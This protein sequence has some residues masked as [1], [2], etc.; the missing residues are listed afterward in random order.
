[1]EK[2]WIW[3]V[4]PF[5]S[6]LCISL[7]Y[8]N[9]LKNLNKVLVDQFSGESSFSLLKYNDYQPVKYF[10]LAVLII[11]TSLGLGYLYIKWIRFDAYQV[12]EV[13]VPFFCIIGLLFLDISVITHINIPIFQAILSACVFGGL[14]VGAISSK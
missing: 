3:R 2:V 1:M 14:V 13:I 4:T 10:I 7:V 5:I 9:K 12:I 6:F 11:F 8:L